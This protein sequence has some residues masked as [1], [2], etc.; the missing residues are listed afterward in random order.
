MMK[1]VITVIALTAL[2]IIMVVGAQDE[3]KTLGHI[4]MCQ[5]PDLG[6]MAGVELYSDE[7]F[8]ALDEEWSV[9]A[10][11]DV[12]AETNHP[13]YGLVHQV[14]EINHKIEE[15]E[16]VSTGGA[17]WQW[18]HD[19][20][21]EALQQQHDDAITAAIACLEDHPYHDSNRGIPDD[22]LQPGMKWCDC[23]EVPPMT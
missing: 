19:V 18:N 12:R 2:F 7:Y 10:E 14:T 23:S 15:I 21:Y 16:E 3:T 4:G 17:H 20:D 1:V 22:G 13:C 11:T 6:P 9:Q 5:C 8:A